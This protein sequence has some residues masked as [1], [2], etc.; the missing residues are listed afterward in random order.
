MDGNVFSLRFLPAKYKHELTVRHILT[1]RTHP[2]ATYNRRTL[3]LHA[4]CSIYEFEGNEGGPKHWLCNLSF[5]FHHA[6]LRES[7]QY[8]HIN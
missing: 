7:L 3:F 1:L 5:I 2:D 4:S 8:E 6:A